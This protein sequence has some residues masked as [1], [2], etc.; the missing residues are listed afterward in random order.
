MAGFEQLR[1][2]KESLDLLPPGVEKVFLRS[3]SAGINTI[4]CGIARRVRM[5]GL[6]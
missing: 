3:D 2:F 6:G 5:S 4:F 1:V